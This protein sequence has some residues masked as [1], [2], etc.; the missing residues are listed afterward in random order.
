MKIVKFISIQ[1]TKMIQRKNTYERGIN[2]NFG[3]K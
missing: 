1:I 2:E 3:K